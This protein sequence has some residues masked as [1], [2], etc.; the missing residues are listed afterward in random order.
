MQQLTCEY[1]AA[2]NRRNC[3]FL[4]NGAVPLHSIGH[5]IRLEIWHPL[6]ALCEQLCCHVSLLLEGGKCEKGSVIYC[7]M[8]Q[9]LWE[10]TVRESSIF[11]CMLLP[12]K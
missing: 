6:E 12:L 1:W 9:L 2:V 11:K 5:S 10:V 4:L 7:K 8:S 3:L